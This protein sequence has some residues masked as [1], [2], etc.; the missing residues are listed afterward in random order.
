G[1]LFKIDSKFT[2]EGTSGEKGTGLGLSLVT[3]IVNIHGGEIWVESKFGSGSK[4]LFTIAV[5]SAEI[6][7]VDDSRTDRIL[8]SK[9]LRS[10]MPKYHITESTN[11]LE[12]LEYLQTAT[13]AIIISD[14]GMP[15]MNGLEFVKKIMESDF[16]YKPPVIIL[17]SDLTRTLT[18]DYR[19]SGVDFVFTKPVN[20]SAFKIAIEKS[21]KKAIF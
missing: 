6:H 3:E 20:L 18:E 1:K 21:L 9:L 13:P 11:G 7:I 16:R 19:E 5:S 10:I 2:L 8:Y 15:V 14:H 17:S 12:A 4:F